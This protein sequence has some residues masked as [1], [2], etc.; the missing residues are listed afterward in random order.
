MEDKG[1]LIRDFEFGA[2]I[3][4][5]ISWI[6]QNDSAENLN[7]VVGEWEKLILNKNIEI[8]VF[9]E[10]ADQTEHSFPQLLV[11]SLWSKP[12]NR[13]KEAFLYAVEQWGMNTD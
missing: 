7:N 10:R 4:F 3:R 12:F 11:R 8:V 6:N 5:A 1:E 9:T 13:T 2:K